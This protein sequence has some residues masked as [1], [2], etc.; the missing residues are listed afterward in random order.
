MSSTQYQAPAALHATGWSS[1]PAPTCSSLSEYFWGFLLPWLFFRSFFSSAWHL[2]SESPLLLC[3]VWYFFSAAWMRQEKA[4]STVR[5]LPRPQHPLLGVGCWEMQDPHGPESKQG[6]EQSDIGENAVLRVVT[7]VMA[8]DPSVTRG[9]SVPKQGDGRRGSSRNGNHRDMGANA[10]TAD[11]SV[12]HTQ[13]PGV[14]LHLL[15][16]LRQELVVEGLELQEEK[17]QFL[18]E[19]WWGEGLRGQS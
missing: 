19:G 13:V 4:L 18:G 1:R 12:T 16:Q 6:W 2:S 5:P 11:K 14:Q 8:G 3:S 17:T 15:L 7:R 10:C 9:T